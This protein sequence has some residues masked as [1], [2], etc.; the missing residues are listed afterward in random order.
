MRW[1]D[2][3]WESGVREVQMPFTPMRV[4]EM[5]GQVKVAAE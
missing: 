5:L 1:Q 3:L 4:W 2:A